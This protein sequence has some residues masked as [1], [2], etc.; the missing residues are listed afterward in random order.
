MWPE[1]T[2]VHERIIV[3]ECGFP[4]GQENVWSRGQHPGQ[5]GVGL[6]VVAEQ[7]QNL[8]LHARTRAG[9]V[10]DQQR[11]AHRQGGHEAALGLI[12]PLEQ[13]QDLSRQREKGGQ[14]E[15]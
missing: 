6:G 7:R 15:P 2:V 11:L 5:Y 14:S 10:V 1:Y 9:V 3:A 13:D 12:V 8:Q 4:Q